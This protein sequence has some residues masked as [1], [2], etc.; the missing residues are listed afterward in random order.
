MST[1][2]VMPKQGQSVESCV[3]LEWM[4]KKGDKINLGDILF[5]YETDKAS[6]EFESPV[7]GVL[8]ETFFNAQDDVPVLTNV[9]VIGETGENVDQFRPGTAQPAKVQEAP[10]AQPSA[11]APQAA[12]PMAQSSQVGIASDGASAPASPRAKRKAEERG[13]NVSVLAGSGPKGRII[14]RDVLAQPALTKTAAARGKAE[15]LVAP[16]SGPGIGGRIRATDLVAASQRIAGT[17]VEDMVTEIRLSN[18]RKIIGTRMLQ[19]LQQCAQLTMSAY[20]DA[21][22]M[23]AFRKKLKAKSKDLALPDISVT[24]LIAFAV[25]K[26]LPAFKELNC[27]YKDE[28]LLRYD[29]VHLAM[30]V[31][32]ER[33]LMVP[34][35][36]FADTLPL[37]ALS[38]G[39]KD[40][41]SQCREG[42][43]NP[44]LL[45]GGTITISNLGMFGIDNFTPILN[46]PQ[47]AILGVNGISARPS[48]AESGEFTVKPHIGFSLT[49]DHRIVDGAPQPGFSRRC[50]TT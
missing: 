48:Q 13:I 3:I 33:G 32:T 38:A 5:S 42:A 18:M 21:T 8:L 50:A 6:F 11:K 12:A 44:D 31:D 41:A 17:P 10:S 28:K 47:V 15:G 29:H 23:L 40:L 24:D 7:A 45:T 39:L 22:S 20:A 26:T 25:A 43:I 46:P 49:I 34:V 1:P 30:A 37:A 27:L 35:M 36:R 2:V 16:V 14:E 19:S 9:A 4:K